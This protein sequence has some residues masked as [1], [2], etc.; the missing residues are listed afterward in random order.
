[1]N[2]ADLDAAIPGAAQVAL[3]PGDPTAFWL[4]SPGA[5]QVPKLSAETALVAERPRITLDP[6]NVSKGLGQLVI[7]LVKL[8]HDLLERQAIRRMEGGTLSDEQVEKLGVT[9]MKQAEEIQK[10]CR[11]FGVKESDLNLDLGPLGRLL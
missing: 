8:I 7:T 3:G 6:E 1:L 2:V 4:E 9:L 10:L 5:Q 11:E